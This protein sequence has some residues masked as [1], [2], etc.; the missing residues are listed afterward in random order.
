MSMA[1]VLQRAG[2]GVWRV[3]MLEVRRRTT[4]H[5]LPAVALTAPVNVLLADRVTAALT[6]ATGQR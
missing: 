3:V 1:R 2:V 6:I 5:G 4:A